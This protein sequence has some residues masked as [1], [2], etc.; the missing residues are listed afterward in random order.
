[1]E[2]IKQFI[3]LL[4]DASENEQTADNLR[5]AI[6][7]HFNTHFKQENN[8]LLMKF[9][10]EVKQLMGPDE[11]MYNIICA[12]D[13]KKEFQQSF[14][15]LTSN[16]YFAEPLELSELAKIKEALEAKNRA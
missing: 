16:D 10:A 1:M 9:L 15:S 7:C 3:D 6:P 5:Q 11:F 2:A 13:T 4:K 14:E 12:F 8:D